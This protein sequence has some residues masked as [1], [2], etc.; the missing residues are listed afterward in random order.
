[1]EKS[2][3]LVVP[4]RSG[5][6]REVTRIFSDNGVS[7]LRMSYNRVVDVH[8]VFV[9]VW[10]SS[11]SVAA[12]EDELRAWR[13]M[14]GQRRVGEVRLLEFAGDN[15]IPPLDPI[16]S[17]IN[18]H[19]LNITYITARTDGNAANVV[20]VGVYVE[21]LERF[22]AM[23][24]DAQATF[25]AREVPHGEYPQL[26]DNNHFNLSFAHGLARK[27]GLDAAAEE[28]ILINSNRIM[29]NLEQQEADPFHPFSFI[30]QVGETI[31]AYRGEAYG[32]ACRV[33]RLSTA[34]GLG[35]ACVEP[36]VGSNTWVFECDDCLLCVDAGYYCMA[37]ELEGVLRGLY[38]DWDQRRKELVLTHA[39][40]DHVGDASRFDCVY[41]SGRVV[42][43]FSFETMGI[44]SWRE[45]NPLSLPYT[46]IGNAL[47]SYHTPDLQRLR[48]LGEPSPFGEQAELFRQIDTLEV[49]PLSFEVWEGKG[50]H[51]RGETVLIERTHRICVSGD[52]FVN[53]RN[54]TKPQARYNTLG[55]YLMTS[56]DTDA[57]LA[58]EERTELFNMLGEGAWQVLGG[59]GAVFDWRAREV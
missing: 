59:H 15:D 3:A 54:Q 6:L 57:D 49:A 47:T 25:Q 14:P 7:I 21:D 11:A 31:A 24:S 8:A 33:T 35:F 23:L 22:H 20:R 56:V 58:R 34:A 48:C 44:F 43:N 10:G 46:R 1:M 19:E 28:E 5:L 29:Q 42:D 45:H 4:D 30:N 18:R 40:V 55:P 32:K 51:V 53:V 27:L 13:F 38:P 37:D 36:P 16:I 17:L 52:I 41:A 9:D 39:D 50:G 26:L 12:A 2:L